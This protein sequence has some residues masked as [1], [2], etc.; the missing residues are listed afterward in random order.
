MFTTI[1]SNDAGKLD[2]TIQQLR[3]EL[4]NDDFTTFINDPI[5]KQ[6]GTTFLHMAAEDNAVNCIQVFPQS[7]IC[8]NW[9]C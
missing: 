9:S 7:N 4:T 6:N 1:K 5:D 3:I 8:T 2:R